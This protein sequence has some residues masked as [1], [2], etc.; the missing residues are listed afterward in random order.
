MHGEFP[1]TSLQERLQHEAEDSQSTA[2]ISFMDCSI[3]RDE[4]MAEKSPTYLVL[5]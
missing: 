3:L 2:G 1:T 4:R 5:V